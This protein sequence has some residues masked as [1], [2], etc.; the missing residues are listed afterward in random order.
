MPVMTTSKPQRL[1]PRKQ[2]M[3]VLA[4]TPLLAPQLQQLVQT[5]LVVTTET[6]ETMQ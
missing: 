2:F 4:T 3:V 5:N 6:R 1:L